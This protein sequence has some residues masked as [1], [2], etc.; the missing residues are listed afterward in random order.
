MKAFKVL[1]Q[2]ENFQY[3]H[4]D[5]GHCNV[6]E[7]PTGSGKSAIAFS[8]LTRIVGTATASLQVRLALG[9]HSF[10]ILTRIVGTATALKLLICSTETS[11]YGLKADKLWMGYS[12]NSL[13]FQTYP[14][15]NRFLR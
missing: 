5:R 13:H 3:P 1:R 4:S 12:T 2:D 15:G 7:A 9:K 8:I 11:N 6:L 14:F 10:S